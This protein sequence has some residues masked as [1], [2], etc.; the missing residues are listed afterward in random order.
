MVETEEAVDISHTEVDKH[1]DNIADEKPMSKRQLK[2]QKRQEKWLTQKTERR[3]IIIV[4][5]I[6]Y[7]FL[8]SDINQWC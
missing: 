7:F 3:Y 8:H 4:S 6:Y 2:L 1:D 5:F